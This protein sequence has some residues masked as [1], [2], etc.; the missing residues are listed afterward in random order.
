M[1]L[2]STA[3]GDRASAIESRQEMTCPD[4][5]N[6]QVGDLIWWN[7]GA[8]VGHVQAIA[9]SKAEYEKWGLD[10]PHAFF[11]NTH[12]FDP[13]TTG[14]AHP[15]GCFVDEGIGV[16]TDVES[17]ELDRAM[18]CANVFPRSGLHQRIFSVTTRAEGCAMIE[19][20][21]QF[22]GT[23]KTN[24]PIVVPRIT[25]NSEQKSS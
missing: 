2:L 15:V 8:C 25:T 11:G 3:D 6:M 24:K 10:G 13:D 19:W 23:D 5:T 9:E 7:E 16:L 12:P 1:P 4:G 22:Q 18:R 17:A 14:V 20:V 21:F